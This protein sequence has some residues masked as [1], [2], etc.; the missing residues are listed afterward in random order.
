M[1]DQIECRNVYYVIIKISSN[2]SVYCQY[3]IILLDLS[4][5]KFTGVLGTDIRKTSRP[6]LPLFFLLS[7]WD[8][9]GK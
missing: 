3:T 9:Y 2:E 5:G 7:N 6:V 4:K 1:V 8:G